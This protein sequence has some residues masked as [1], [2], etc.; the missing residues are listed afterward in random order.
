MINIVI[1]NY[2]IHRSHIGY[3]NIILQQSFHVLFILFISLQIRHLIYI[4]HHVV[5]CKITTKVYKSEYLE[6]YKVTDT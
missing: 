1:V 2:V 3:A 5:I 6:K 4:L